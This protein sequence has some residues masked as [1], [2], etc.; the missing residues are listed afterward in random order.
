M[1]K[2]FSAMQKRAFFAD[3]V[4]DE[5]PDETKTKQRAHGLTPGISRAYAW[6]MLRTAAAGAMCCCSPMPAC[7]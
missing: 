1:T 5:I 6:G 7:G 4:A 2:L 3:E